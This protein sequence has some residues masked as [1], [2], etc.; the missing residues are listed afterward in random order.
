LC[1]NTPADGSI[2]LDRVSIHQLGNHLAVI[3]GFV[4][5]MLADAPPDDPHRQD[6][7]DVRA[8]A[9]AVAKLIGVGH[10]VSS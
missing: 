5:L 10:N 2:T 6:L 4:E 3:V 1:A 8:A 7:L 9:V